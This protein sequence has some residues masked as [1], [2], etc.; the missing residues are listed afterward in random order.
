MGYRLEL[1]LKHPR[2]G[3]RVNTESIQEPF[4]ECFPPKNLKPSQPEWWLSSSRTATTLLTYNA[5]K[6]R[7]GSQG[8]LPFT[9]APRR[10]IYAAGE[11]RSQQGLVPDHNLEGQRSTMY[12]IIFI[13][14]ARS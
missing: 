3:R 4:S 6:S 2:G 10:T 11:S 13:P 9:I 1:V 14:G 8:A 5:I 7:L 12:D